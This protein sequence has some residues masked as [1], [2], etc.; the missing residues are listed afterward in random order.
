MAVPEAEKQLAEKSAVPGKGTGD[1]RLGTTIT[2]RNSKKR[3]EEEEEEYDDGGD[4]HEEIEGD[5]QLG[6]LPTGLG[7]SSDSD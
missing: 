7:L 3:V 5:L 4:E 1:G 6:Q 2:R